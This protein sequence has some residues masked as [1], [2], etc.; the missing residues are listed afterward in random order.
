MLWAFTFPLSQA[1]CSAGKK[2][3]L[4]DCWV[5]CS[6]PAAK[7]GWSTDGSPSSLSSSSKS[8][9]S[10]PSA[11]GEDMVVLLR[12]DW[13]IDGRVSS[14]LG[15][16]T[17]LPRAGDAKVPLSLEGS[18]DAVASA[19]GDP[20]EWKVPSSLGGGGPSSPRLESVAA[21]LSGSSS[22]WS[23]VGYNDDGMRI[24][25]WCD[26]LMVAMILVLMLV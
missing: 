2:G 4:P 22:I 24:D 1:T 6:C 11:R 17:S 10:S 21:S 25:H 9:L 15:G 18:L 12:G 8:T 26:V 7:E 14:S 16:G 20:S 3:Q 13:A 5:V 23:P 19:A